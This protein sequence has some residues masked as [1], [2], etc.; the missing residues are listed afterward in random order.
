MRFTYD[1]T[2][3]H[4]L[5]AINAVLDLFQDHPTLSPRMAAVH[6]VPNHLAF[7]VRP[8]R[9]TCNGLGVGGENF[10]FFCEKSPFSAP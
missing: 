7:S 4:Q 6:A 10:R 3:P 8:C 2:Q 5:T 9:K 1:S